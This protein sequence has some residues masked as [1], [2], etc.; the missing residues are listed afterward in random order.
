MLIF[1]T[2]TQFILLIIVFL[3]AVMHGYQ[4][5]VLVV[6]QQ[7]VKQCYIQ[8]VKRTLCYIWK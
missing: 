2:I 8:L 6:C 1:I 5:L 7:G 4:K 3:I